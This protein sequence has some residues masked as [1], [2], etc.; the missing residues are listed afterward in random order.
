MRKHNMGAIERVI[1]VLAGAL[2]SLYAGF[3]PGMG[4]P[5]LD[6][7]GFFWNSQAGTSSVVGFIVLLV[8]IVIFITGWAA[9]CP[10]NALIHANSCKACR[11]GETHA[12]MPV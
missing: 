4:T 11:V 6:A 12:H 3:Y 10:V 8:G 2:I 1:R 9:Y 7:F 5:G